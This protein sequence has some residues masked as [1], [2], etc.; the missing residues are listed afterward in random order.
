MHSSSSS[1]R[2]PRRDLA[3]GIQ[4]MRMQRRAF[5]RTARTFARGYFF[6]FIF[7]L[8]ASRSL[9]LPERILT[10]VWLRL[11]GSPRSLLSAPPVRL[12][13][14]TSADTDRATL[15]HLPVFPKPAPPSP[16]RSLRTFGVSTAEK[17]KGRTRIILYMFNL[18]DYLFTLCR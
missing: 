1:G 15:V 12:T 16:R 7:G 18:T 13:K 10:L 6:F 17:R 2:S 5:R 4:C 8:V 3:A 9:A 11:R 14:H